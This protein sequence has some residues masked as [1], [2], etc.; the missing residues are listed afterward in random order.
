MR[1]R[2]GADEPEIAAAAERVGVTPVA[3]MPGWGALLD[4]DQMRR[5]IHKRS[6]VSRTESTNE[7]RQPSRLEKKKNTHA[8]C[9]AGAPPDTRC[10]RCLRLDGALPHPGHTQDRGSGHA[11]PDES[12]SG[13]ELPYPP[14]A[15]WAS[16]PLP[17]EGSRDPLACRWPVRLVAPASGQWDVAAHRT[18]LCPNGP[19]RLRLAGPVVWVGDPR[20]QR[21]ETH[22]RSAG[23]HRNPGEHPT[24]SRPPAGAPVAAPSSAP[25]AS[26]RSPFRRIPNC[27]GE[28]GDNTAPKAFDASTARARSHT[29]GV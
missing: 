6:N 15:P 29:V 20:S 8:G 25:G 27:G 5:K 19:R 22:G 26:R 17:D 18:P 14:C 24:R 28:P 11:A 3:A 16:A 13:G 2:P 23:K 12:R 21:G 10:V 7:P 4:H 9:P 1:G